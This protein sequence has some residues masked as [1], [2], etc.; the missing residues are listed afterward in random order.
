MFADLLRDSWL[1]SRSRAL[2][3]QFL[4]SQN[5]Y[6]D[7]AESAMR[8]EVLGKLDM[9]VK[10][11]IRKVTVKRGLNN[12]VQD[13]NAKI[14]TFGSYRLGVHGPGMG[15]NGNHSFQIEAVTVAASARLSASLSMHRSSICALLSSMTAGSELRWWMKTV[16]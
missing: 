6:E 5:L 16:H 10:E 13:A 4:R 8:E 3:V 2:G 1:A 9:L 11:W 12:A 7:A 14:F 15:H